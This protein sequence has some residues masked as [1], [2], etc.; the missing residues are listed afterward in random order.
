MA[1]ARVVVR[2]SRIIVL[3]EA[4]SSVDVETD[5]SIQNTIKAE[6]GATTLLCIVRLP[7]FSLSLHPLCFC[8]FFFTS[9][10]QIV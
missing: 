8:F 5:Q 10:P 6:F 1:L 2:N 4:T 7:S 9:P 3:D